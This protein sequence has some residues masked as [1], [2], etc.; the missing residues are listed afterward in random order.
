MMPGMDGIE[1]MKAIRSDK[2]SLSQ[3][4]MPIVALTANA[5]STA[6]EMFLSEGFDGF[7]SKPVEIAELERVLKRVLPASA[8]VY[9]NIA[10]NKT[11]DGNVYGTLKKAGIDTK[12]GLRYSQRDVELYQTLL[13]QYVKEAPEKQEKING[14]Y[15]DKDYKN[16]EILVH[17]LKSTSRMI[18]ATDMSE[19]AKRLEELAKAGGSEIT[20]EMHDAMM[21]MYRKTVSAISKAMESEVKE[22]PVSHEPEEEKKPAAG[23]L[24]FMPSNENKGPVVLEFTP[25]DIIP[26]QGGD[27][28]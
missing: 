22:E 3:R 13:K 4:D 18:G 20:G 26:R 7:V 23:V 14:Y 27:A 15:K 10:G 8:I 1:A 25:D 12:A 11:D 6:K 24:E 5:V 28:S 9:E 2:G 16:Y 17:A 19:K 21:A